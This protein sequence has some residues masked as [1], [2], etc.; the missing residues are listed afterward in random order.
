MLAALCGGC[1][2]PVGGL[3][4]VEEDGLLHLSGVVL[5]GDG[6]QRIFAES[7]APPDAAEDLGR[8]VAVE[9][10]A[11]GAAELIRSTRESG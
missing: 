4:R 2:A 9:L 1:L 11:R 5:R 6:K 10:L 3:G 7:S 8:Y